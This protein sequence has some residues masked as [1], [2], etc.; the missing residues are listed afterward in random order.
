MPDVKPIDEIKYDFK[1]SKHEVVPKLPM[2]AMIVGPSGSGKSTLLVSMILDIYRGA[3][4]RIFIWSP[5]VNL[6]SI[7]LPVKKYIKEGLKVDNDKEPCWWDEFNV[8]DLE[9]VIETQNKIIK[10]QKKQGTK[11]LFNISNFG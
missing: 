3:F 10:Y 7:W 5:S 8:E 4:E 2:R 11:T 9:R 1:Q 6:D